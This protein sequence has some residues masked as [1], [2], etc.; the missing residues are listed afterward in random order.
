MPTAEKEAFVEEFAG[1]LS[2]AKGVLL[3]DFSGMDVATATALRNDLRKRNVRY[4]VVKNTLL[5]LA[6][7]QSGMEALEPY[8]Q[9]PTALA[10]S[11]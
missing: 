4:F 2:E 10:Y 11:T 9:G 3:A 1:K 6:A 8:L 7:R 5:R